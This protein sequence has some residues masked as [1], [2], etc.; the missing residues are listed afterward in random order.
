MKLPRRY[1]NSHSMSASSNL[2]AGA[3]IA[4]SGG[5]FFDSLAAQAVTTFVGKP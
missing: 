4:V 1:S 2:T 3:A 5:R